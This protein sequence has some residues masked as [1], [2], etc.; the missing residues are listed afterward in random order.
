M[1]LSVWSRS[2]SLWRLPP[3]VPQIVL[4]ANH[5]R[6]AVPDY[7]NAVYRPAMTALK[8]TA[9]LVAMPAFRAPAAVTLPDKTSG[10]NGIA[11]HDLKY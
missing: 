10:F 6:G 11:V 2:S 9:A 1:R 3:C 8:W 5:A 4:S 7:Q